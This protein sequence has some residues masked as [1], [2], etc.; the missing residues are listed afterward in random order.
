VRAP[1]PEPDVGTLVRQLAALAGPG[2]EGAPGLAVSAPEPGAARTGAGPDLVRL[3]VAAA[4]AAALAGAGPAECVVAVDGDGAVRLAL[5]APHPLALDAGLAALA[6]AG[7]V[8][9]GAPDAPAVAGLTL[10]FPS[11]L[12]KP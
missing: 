9:V 4:V 5:S 12:A 3:L 1:A 11:A 6:A 10:T 7:G 2:A 8:A